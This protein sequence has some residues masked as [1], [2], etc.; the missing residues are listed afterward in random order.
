MKSTIHFRN[1]QISIAL[2]FFLLF[3]RQKSMSQC[4]SALPGMTVNGVAITGGGDFFI[5]EGNETACTYTTPNNSLK[6]SFNTQDPIYNFNFSKPVNNL[7]FVLTAEFDRFD[8]W[9]LEFTASSGPIS[10]E[11][12]GSCNNL[13]AD[14]NRI[15]S[16]YHRSGAVR[17]GGE[18][19]VSVPGGFTSLTFRSLPSIAES[20]ALCAESIIPCPDIPTL[21]AITQP[22]CENLTG[23]FRIINFDPTNT[24][25]VSPS[26]NTSIS[27]EGVVTVPPGGSY[28]V[29]AGNATCTSNVSAA[30]VVN[31]L[32]CAQ[33]DVYSIE[34]N[35]TLTANLRE[36]DG[37]IPEGE[38][39][40]IPRPDPAF[41]NPSACVPLVVNNSPEEKT[42]T[43]TCTTAG[44]YHYLVPVRAGGAT[45]QVPLTITVNPALPV[46]LIFFNAKQEVQLVNLEWETT[47]ETNSDRFEIQWKA[48]GDWNKV[49]SVAAAGESNGLRRY[50]FQHNE[51]AAGQNLYRLKMI[52]RASDRQGETFAYSQIKNVLIEAMETISIYPNPVVNGKLYLNDWS[53]VKALELYNQKGQKVRSYLPGEKGKM[54]VSSLQSGLYVIKVMLENGTSTSG[55]IL[56]SN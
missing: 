18:F 45:V 1:I 37:Y 12:T 46:T 30:A 44:V 36:N 4:T 17:G 10:I 41:T 53:N 39:Y 3:A 6:A 11:I 56:I 47:E 25:T 14:G 34:V 21:S 5:R 28:T 42:L 26:E 40:F 29:T 2:C 49:G 16:D 51:P 22:T 43:F 32:I 7:R 19:I 27:S 33:A 38:T 50:T 9:R 8:F 23:S 52:D 20:I 48:A 55:K 13:V 35:Q 31:N 24:Y 15:Y 54:D